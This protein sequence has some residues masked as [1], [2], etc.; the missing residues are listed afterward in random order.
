MSVFR[1]VSV[2]RSFKKLPAFLLLAIAVVLSSCT[3]DPDPEGPVYLSEVFEYVYGPGQHAA[4]AQ[5]LDTQYLTG[6]P[7]RHQ[8]WLYLGG[9][10]GYVIAGFPR[11][12]KNEEGADFELIALK[13]AAPEPAIVFVMADTNGNGRPDETW[14]E[15]AGSLQDETVRNYSVSY[16]KP[17][18]AGANIR[19]EDNRGASGE[20][21]SMYGSAS[22][23]SWWWPGTPADRI[24]FTG[25]RLPAIY[26]NTDGI[27][28]V[29]TNRVQWGYAENNYG[30]DYD[31]STGSNW[32]D[33]SN[34][35]DEKGMPAKLATIRFLKIQSAVFQQ[36]G[37]TNEVSPEIRGARSKY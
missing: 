28:K 13:G 25:S 19:W 24:T 23:A 34:A 6:N 26:E 29:P 12:I 22:S 11:D 35:I 1:T 32:L 36:A 5:P 33:I 4:M 37:Q 16:F 8:G 17:E 9:Y 2:F 14:Y 20:L 15:L 30:T 21:Q 18:S 27:W 10:G 3:P 31:A 7:D